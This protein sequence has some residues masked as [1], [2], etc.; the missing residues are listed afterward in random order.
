MQLRDQGGLT[1]VPAR[2]VVLGRQD[3]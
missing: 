1:V 3:L 2:G